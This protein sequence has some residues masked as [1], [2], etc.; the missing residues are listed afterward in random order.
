MALQALIYVYIRAGSTGSI[1]TLQSAGSTYSIHS[2]QAL[3]GLYI[4]FFCHS[5]GSTDCRL[6]ALGGARLEW[7]KG[8]TP[9]VADG[10]HA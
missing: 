3:Q 9:R 4:F 2:L 1:Q 10:Q 5:A 7:Q 6:E 8:S